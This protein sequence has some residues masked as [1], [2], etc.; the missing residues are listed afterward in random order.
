MRNFIID[1]MSNDEI[2]TMLHNLNSLTRKKYNS[3]EEISL[4][5]I[6]STSKPVI[7]RNVIEFFSRRDWLA[8]LIDAAYAMRPDAFVE[9][10]PD[11]I[12]EDS[13]GATTVVGSNNTVAGAGGVAIGGQNFGTIITNGGAVITGNVTVV[14]GEWVGRDKITSQINHYGA[15]PRW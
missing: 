6:G 7:A 14:D 8:D 12:H 3:K 10:F 1:S 13:S 11:E 5:V 4:D 2:G 15:K 9:T